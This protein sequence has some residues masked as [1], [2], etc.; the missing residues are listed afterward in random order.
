MTFEWPE[1]AEREG[2]DEGETGGPVQVAANEVAFSWE[3]RVGEKGSTLRGKKE[4]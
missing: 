1:R 3:R 4:R 2:S